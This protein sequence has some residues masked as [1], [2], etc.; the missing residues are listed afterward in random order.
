M[1]NKKAKELRKI[2]PPVDEI[3]RRNYR[4]MKKKYDKLP[5]EAKPLFLAELTFIF[6][7]NL[8]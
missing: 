5:K 8:D 7:S 3:S 6:N 2:I 1:N 4:R